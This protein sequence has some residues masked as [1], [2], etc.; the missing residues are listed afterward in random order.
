VGGQYTGSIA[1]MD[2]GELKMN[3]AHSTKSAYVAPTLEKR[4]RI[5][6][7]VENG[8]NTVTSGRVT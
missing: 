5:E 2:M 1:Y 4:Q 8:E 7:V 6:E 3:E